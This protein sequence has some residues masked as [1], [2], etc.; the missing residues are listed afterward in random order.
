MNQY[1]GR[2]HGCVMFTFSSGMPTF[3]LNLTKHNGTR[4]TYYF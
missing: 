3:N 2:S 1:F 4:R